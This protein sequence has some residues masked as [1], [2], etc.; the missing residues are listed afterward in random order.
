MVHFFVEI[1]KHRIEGSNYWTDRKTTGFMK[2]SRITDSTF[3]SFE[4]AKKEHDRIIEDYRMKRL[5]HLTN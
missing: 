5:R 4:L 1:N 2:F 3:E